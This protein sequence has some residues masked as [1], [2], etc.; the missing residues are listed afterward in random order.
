MNPNTSMAG[1]T[2]MGFPAMPVCIS[3]VTSHRE[4]GRGS[5]G[6]SA[7]C[8]FF[9]AFRKP[10]V[11]GLAVKIGQYIQGLQILDIVQPFVIHGPFIGHVEK[12]RPAI[13]IDRPFQ[14]RNA[15]LLHQ[16]LKL[17]QI[18]RKI[19]LIHPDIPIVNNERQGKSL[20]LK[21]PDAPT[22]LVEV[23]HGPFWR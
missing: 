12:Q 4:R 22:N 17:L 10:P 20:P 5:A 3:S 7:V 9:A 13:E 11:A 6:G 18:Q 1:K 21:I 19:P 14:I 23:V 8:Q 15:A 16:A 2:T